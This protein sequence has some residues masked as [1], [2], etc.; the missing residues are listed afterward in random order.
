MPDESF[1]KKQI[2]T[3]IKGAKHIGIVPS[4]MSLA[5]S[6]SA[7]AGLYFM[8]L[9]E[10]DKEELRKEE[11]KTVSLVF[12]E[13]IPESCTNVLNKLDVTSKISERELQVTID[14]AGSGADAFRW[15]NDK[16]LLTV[17]LG[18][19]EKDFDRNRIKSAVLGFDFDIVFTIGMQ[20]FD[21]IEQMYATI[22]KEVK[23][24]R[25]V[26]LDNTSLNTRFGFVN[27]VDTS[28]DT[29]SLLVLQKAV[30]WGLKPNTKSAKAL[31]NGITS[32]P[33]AK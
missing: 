29:L 28:A 4:K 31:L 33:V 5:D 22:N 14:Y 13:E 32:L 6:L 18:P 16:Q 3:L 27:I 23:R 15:T 8:I 9:E 17:F 11:R 1:D 10:L 30:E 24:S 26:N 7:A 21:D 19:V 20:G 12:D 2:L 25:I